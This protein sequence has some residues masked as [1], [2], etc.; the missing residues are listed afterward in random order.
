M[1]D[2]RIATPPPAGSLHNTQRNE[3]HVQ[4]APLDQNRQATVVFASHTCACL[5]DDTVDCQG[6]EGDLVKIGL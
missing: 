4:C 3:V 2:Q 6:C 5:A 1:D